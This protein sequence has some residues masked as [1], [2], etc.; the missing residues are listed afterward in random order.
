MYIN[1]IKKIRE[2]QG[3][4]LEKLASLAGIS[5]GY[6]CHL[7]KGKRNNPSIEVMNNISSA[8]GKSVA[9]VFFE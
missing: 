9:E 3:M 4:T 7:E 2:E 6:I 8:L 5:Q 1:K